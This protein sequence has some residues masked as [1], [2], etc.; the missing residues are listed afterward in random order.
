MYGWMCCHVCAR[1]LA[2]GSDMCCFRGGVFV[3]W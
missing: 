3:S 2:G 1:N